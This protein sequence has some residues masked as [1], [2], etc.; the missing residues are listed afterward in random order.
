MTYQNEGMG[1]PAGSVGCCSILEDDND[2]AFLNDLGPKFNTLADICGGKKATVEHH[3]SLP[4]PPK[5]VAPPENVAINRAVSS[6]TVNVSSNVASTTRMENVVMTEN[7]PTVIASVQPAPTLLVQQQPM[8]YMVEPQPSTLL[9]AERPAVQNM[10]VLNSAPMAEEVVIQGANVTAGHGERMVLLERGGST[11]ALNTGM[12]HAGALSGSQVL[13]V[14]GGAQSGHILQGTLPKGATRSQNVMIV[15]GGQGGVV[16]GSLRKGAS[17][18]V[19]QGLVYG[20]SGVVQGSHQNAAFTAGSINGNVGLSGSSLRN[21][22]MQKVVIQEKKV[23]TS[24]TI[25]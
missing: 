5:P 8:Y 20:G 11:H 18:H 10:Y 15:E 19:S 22:T 9:V 21:P 3:V 4:P 6:N 2:L 24:Q 12:I 25:K 7:R 13:L 14:D 23:V 1:S 16:Q 17:A